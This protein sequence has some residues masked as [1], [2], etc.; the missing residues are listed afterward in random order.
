M[1]GGLP[2]RAF[3]ATDT[4]RRRTAN[5]DRFHADP[6][7]GIFVVVD[8]IGGH[9]AGDTAADAALTAMIERL[10]RQT[11]A[12]TDRMRE[13]ITIANNAVH[14][15]A[16]SRPEWRGM[17]CVATAVAIDGGRA[18][19]GHVGDSRLYRL[20][21][22]GIEKVT[23]DH[24]PV[25]ERE[26]AN[27]MSEVEAMRHPRRNE[28]YRDI[29]SEPRLVSDADF[30]FVTEVDMPPG[31]ALLLCTDGLTDL[32]ASDTLL[33][34]AT[35]HAGS[36]ERVVHA[37]I[38]AANDAGGKDN[39]TAVYVERP[40]G[41]GAW[42]PAGP[43]ASAARAPARAWLLLVAAVMTATGF[44]LGLIAAAPAWSIPRLAARLT[45]SPGDVVVRPGESIMAAIAAAPR[46]TAIV[47]EPGEYREQITLGDGIRLM[48][49]VPR[50]ATIR[51]PADAGDSEA[52][53]VA[54]RVARAEVHGF[55]IV[56][57]AATPLGVGVILREA[58]V[59][60][61]DLDISGAHTAAVDIGAGG[62]V[63]MS[64]SFIHDNPG[65]GL[66]IRA[67]AAPRIAHSVFALNGSSDLLTP[68][69]VLEAGAAPGW[70]QNVFNGMTPDA[71]AG[72]DA[73][74]RLPLARD[75]WFVAPDAA[76]ARTVQRGAA[77]R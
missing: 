37:L 41:A 69:V 53:V 8:G 76:P 14:R 43:A 31:A 32:V 5:E 15:L 33:R 11:G 68:P 57:D 72:R 67:G 27:E 36:P 54:A 65:A 30:V 21:D 56:G 38:E 29:G 51:L 47:V 73:S 52:A 26:D 64:G 66:V 58:G 59:R 6:V 71:L 4:G 25:G 74:A 17:A 63:G 9:A 13:A 62:D 50:G 28:V 49:R 44:G 20:A 70:S 18:V 22:G 23:P 60:L 45:P 48:S 24:S 55:R 34:I 77:D 40:A 35:A 19:V 10:E 75:N 42:V 12:V 2:I 16:A 7:R 3:G 46:G 39:I 61:V 1:S